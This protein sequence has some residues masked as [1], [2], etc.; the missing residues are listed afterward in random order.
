MREISRSARNTI[1]FVAVL[2]TV[3]VGET[4]GTSSGLGIVASAASDEVAA[5]GPCYIDVTETLSVTAASPSDEVR[6]SVDANCRIAVTRTRGTRA[7]PRS[8]SGYRLA[9][10]LADTFKGCRSRNVTWDTLGL[11][12]VERLTSFIE[13]YYGG[14]AV[15][16]VSN[17]DASSY[18][19]PG[20]WY[21]S[22]SVWW[23][24]TPGSLPAWDVR[25]DATVNYYWLGL[26]DANKENDGHAYG[27]GTCGTSFSHT[28][29]VCRYCEVRFYLDYY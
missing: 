17:F 29:N 2:A 18:T 21:S 13:F 7:T 1:A 5:S 11:A 8:S 4:T 27:D 23:P 6:I 15:S 20:S 3:F 10:P 12:D 24:H 25:Y 28:G 26:Y 14:S 9:A 19:A 22:G 16:S